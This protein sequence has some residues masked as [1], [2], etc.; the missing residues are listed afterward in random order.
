M[1]VNSQHDCFYFI[2][3]H[4]LFDHIYRIRKTDN[5]YKRV[6]DKNTKDAKENTSLIGKYTNTFLN[7]YSCKI[8]Q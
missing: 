4:F 1:N 5:D 6:H 8:E 3:K 7:Q 2:S